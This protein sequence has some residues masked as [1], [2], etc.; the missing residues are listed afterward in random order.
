[1]IY[2]RLFMRKRLLV[3]VLALMMVIGM[4][5]PLILNVEAAT[6]YMYEDYIKVAQKY[7]DQGA[8]R[9]K[10][11]CLGFVAYC[12]YEAFGIENT[13]SCCAYNY[14]STHI[15]STSR[16]NIPI[17][18]D[19]YFGGSNITCGTC[20]KK[21]GHIGI[22]VGDGYIIHSWAGKVQ[23]MSIDYVISRGYPYRGYGWHADIELVGGY[24]SEC[25][26][27]YP[28]YGEAVVK[29]ACNPH[30]LP[31]SHGVA[32]QYGTESR[33]MTDKAL[34]PGDKFTING[35]IKNTEGHY[36]YKV[37]LKDGTQGYVYAEECKTMTRL[38]PSVSGSITPDSMNGATYLGGTVQANGAKLNSIQALVYKGK[39]ASGSAVIKSNV[40]KI[41]TTGSYKLEKSAVDYSLPFQDLAKHGAGY[42]TITIEA[43]VTNYYLDKNFKLKES[44]A[45]VTVGTD[46]FAYGNPGGCTHSYTQ[47]VTQPECN[48]QGYTTYTCSKCGDSYKGNYTDS[49]GHNYAETT[50]APTCTQKGHTSVTCARCGHS[51]QTSE[52]AARGHSYEDWYIVNTPTCTQTGLERRECRNCDA[53]EERTLNK[54]GHSYSSQK[55]EPTC[56]E[57]GYTYYYCA[58]CGHSYTDNYVNPTEHS[59]GD[60]TIVETPT[61]VENGVRSRTCTQCGGIQ[62]QTI[63]LADHK[64]S[65]A[66][67]KP[68]CTQKGYTTYT[69]TVCGQSYRDNETAATGHNYSSWKEV[70]ASTCT[71]KGTERRDCNCGHYETRDKAAKGHS[72]GNWYESKAPSCTTKGQEKRD[73]KCG[74]SETREKAATGHSFGN[75]YESKAP[76]CT[77]KGEDKRDCKCGYFETR[78]KAAKGHSYKAVVT[79]P[80][81]TAGGYTTHTCSACGNSYKDTE[82][83]AKGH[84]YGNWT[85]VQAST[86]TAKGQERRDCK[87][88]H[89]ETREKAALGHNYVA[90]VTAPTCTEKGFTTHTCS[91]CNDAYVDTEVAA[92]GH[93]YDAVV[94][95]P[96]CGDAGYTTHTCSSCGHSYA[97]SVVAAKGHSFGEWTETLAP[98][99]TETGIN[100]RSCAACGYV[101]TQDIDAK[102]HSFTVYVSDENATCTEDGTQSASCDNGC[103]AI[104]TQTV[105]N[106]KKGHSF[107]QW[108]VEKEATDTEE[109]R[110]RRECAECGYSESKTVPALN[111]PMEPTSPTEPQSGEKDKED[112]PD[113]SV[114]VVVL[115]A[116]VCV[117][118]TLAGGILIV[119]KKKA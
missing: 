118:A 108:Y 22:Y 67:T 90:V 45:T 89:Y 91:L 39:T 33:P 107:R 104:D 79:E 32:L 63:A 29:N 69:C 103:G 66:V 81:C 15:D 98:T 48:A 74:N 20:G 34:S 76:G 35:I 31:C 61:C 41:S 83:A 92:K 1:M 24:I 40:D 95:D 75:W 113:N 115:V 60:W 85:E 70:K 94:T 102:G 68:T 109:G 49:L 38:N 3:L 114:I 78:E 73:C 51:Y 87:C 25:S 52:V 54:T 17:G 30:P 4:A 19:V 10:D 27:L 119:K 55:I 106:S 116:G 12:F 53:V 50:I 23:K 9:W 93:A 46:V 100:S 88:G 26:T 43:N 96:T 59:F 2:W 86:C 111:K 11:L 18:A 5:S 47:K 62:Q 28:S 112:D 117:A 36:W 77:A 7:A 72:Y 14:G 21:C 6:V 65:T 97:D 71:E 42:Y 105:G 13:S 64:Y 101:E 44:T 58:Y 37:T 82:V 80:T 16:E 57:Q 56:S 8:T 99:C 110:E 84:S